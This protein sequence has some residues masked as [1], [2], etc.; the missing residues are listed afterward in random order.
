MA[1]SK[2]FPDYLKV[3]ES[4]W[5]GDK[6]RNKVNRDEKENPRQNNEI[7]LE[8][9]GEKDQSENLPKAK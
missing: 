3:K 5:S 4:T 1:L 8:L 6:Q 2:E 9:G 7:K